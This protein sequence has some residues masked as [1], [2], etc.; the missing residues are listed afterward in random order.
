M[1]IQ[2]NIDINDDENVHEIVKLLQSLNY[3]NRV[4]IIPQKP[5]P[6]PTKSRFNRFYGAAKTGLSTT[7]L[8]E[9]FDNR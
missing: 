8:A 7:E 1:D 5:S 2:I 4:E 3:I 6:M 9:I